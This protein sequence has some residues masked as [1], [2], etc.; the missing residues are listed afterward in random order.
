M[1]TQIS[2]KNLISVKNGLDL[3]LQSTPFF[4]DQLNSPKSSQFNFRMSTLR[5]SAMRTSRRWKSSTMQWR[6]IHSQMSKQVYCRIQNPFQGRQAFRR[7]ILFDWQK[8]S[9]NSIGNLQKWSGWRSLH[10]LWRLVAIQIGSLSA[11]D[12]KGTWRTRHQNL[13]LGS[14]KWNSI[15]VD[16]QQVNENFKF[17]FNFKTH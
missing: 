8:H 3:A 1:S 13:G 12:W 10:S 7:K 9:A 4:N 16:C 11:C 15:L 17:N 5:Y 2:I 6:R 14:W